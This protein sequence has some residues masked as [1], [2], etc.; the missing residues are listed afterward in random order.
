MSVTLESREEMLE[1]YPFLKAG[2]EGIC[3]KHSQDAETILAWSEISLVRAYKL[4]TKI[5]IL[6]VLEIE[7]ES[8]EFVEMFSNWEGFRCVVEGI[9]STLGGIESGW[10]QR[11]D[12]LSPTD[13]TLLLWRREQEGTS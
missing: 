2:A 10:S 12:S 8:G 4:D 1:E 5:E 7:T 9:S 11:V 3:L 13:D 6:T